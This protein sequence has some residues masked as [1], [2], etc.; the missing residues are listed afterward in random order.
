MNADGDKLD[1]VRVST[2]SPERASRTFVPTAQHPLRTC[3]HRY[4]VLRAPCSAG[5]CEKLVGSMHAA[6][7]HV[8]PPLPDP[9]D[10][11]VPRYSRHA[12]P[13]YRYVPGLQPHP[14]RDP[15]G[16]TYGGRQTPAA[17]VPAADDA[18]HVDAWRFGVDLFN[19]FYFWEAHEAWE[20]VWRA[21]PPDAPV[22]DLVHGLIQV[23]AALLKLHLG[24]VEAARRLAAS[25]IVK[26]RRADAGSLVL[27]VSPAA[28]AAAFAAYFAPVLAGHVAA[29]CAA[30]R[31]RRFVVSRPPRGLRRGGRWRPAGAPVRLT[32][33]GLRSVAS[34]STPRR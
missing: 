17:V 2:G 34:G 20:D 22:R 33:R 4:C 7:G 21:A 16:H 25:G 15:A 14:T 29:G 10:R 8:P 31:V 9:G 1:R 30:P 5:S 32:D 13:P 19:Q 27:G 28:V 26:I 18:A 6:S 3:A 12:L 23:A 24:R 11:G